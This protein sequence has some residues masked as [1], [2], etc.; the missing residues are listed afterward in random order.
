M[1]FETVINEINTL[2]KEL[3]HTKDTSAKIALMYFCSR[4][5]E[6]LKSLKNGLKE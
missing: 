6:K 4:L 2:E 3:T 1:K 5:R